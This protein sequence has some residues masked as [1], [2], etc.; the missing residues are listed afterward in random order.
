[1]FKKII[2][3]TS[4]LIAGQMPTVPCRLSSTKKYSLFEPDYLDSLKPKYPQYESLNVSIKGYDYPILESYQRF[5][6]SLAE[7]LDLDVSDCYALPPQQSKIQ[8]YR[9]NSTIIDSEYKLTMY[10]RNLQINDVDV[11]IYPVFLR[12][13]QSALPEGVNLSV[14]EHDDDCEE[15]RYVP[16]KDLLELKAQLEEM[17]ASKKK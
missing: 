16:D 12:I 14:Q 4:R 17:Q 10:E 7:Y 15:R 6:H 11:P 3:L 8:R 9:P 1:M 13:A 2:P 5:L